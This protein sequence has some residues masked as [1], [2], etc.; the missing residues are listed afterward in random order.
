MTSTFVQ[1]KICDDIPTTICKHKRLHPEHRSDSINVFLVA[2]GKMENLKPSPSGEFIYQYKHTTTTNN[3]T[4]VFKMEDT[5][6]EKFLLHCH[7]VLFS[8]F[9]FQLDIINIFIMT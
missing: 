3:M 6:I 4:L 8:D 1:L 2:K 5:A 7:N 9:S